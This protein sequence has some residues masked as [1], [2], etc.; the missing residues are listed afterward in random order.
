M[1]GEAAAAAREKRRRER[2][3]AHAQYGTNV[4]ESEAALVAVG[5]TK[6]NADMGAAGRVDISHGDTPAQ[7]GGQS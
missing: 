1:G 3:R 4:I 5:L 6:S 7:G 2:A